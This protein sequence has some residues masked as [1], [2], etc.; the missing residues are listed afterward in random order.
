M[1]R[2]L[3]CACS[4]GVG[5]RFPG[6]GGK[7]ALGGPMRCYWWGTVN[8]AE[9]KKNS[10]RRESQQVPLFDGQVAGEQL[11]PRSHHGYCLLLGGE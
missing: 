6:E 9:E 4:V 1:R 7:T 2:F 10:S 3:F 11:A 5:S 8:A